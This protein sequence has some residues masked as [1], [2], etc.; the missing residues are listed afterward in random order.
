MTKKQNCSFGF[1][2]RMLSV[3][4]AV[5]MMLSVSVVSLV[6]SVSAAD[7]KTI[8]VGIISYLN[9][10]TNNYRVHYWDPAP[11]MPP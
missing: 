4:L 2:K 7:T 9:L 1:G 11:T 10:S 8:Y 3:L 5:L 6:S